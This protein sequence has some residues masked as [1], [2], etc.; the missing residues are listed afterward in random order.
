MRPHT[1]H[2]SFLIT[3]A[4]LALC[5]QALLAGT[6]FESTQTTEA[7]GKRGDQKVVVAGW[8][9]G[10]GA[11]VEFRE[12]TSPMVSEG[13]YIV[14]RDGGETAYLV[15]PEEK[16]YME[17]DL[18]AL[19]GSLGNMMQGMGGMVDMEFRDQRVEKVGEEPGPEIV[20]HPTTHHTYES[21]YTLVIRVMGM[22]R[23]MRTETVQEIWSTPELSAPGFGLWL[24]EAPE[25][26]IEGLDEYLEQE[27]SKAEGFP[28]RTKT[29][30][31]TIGQKGRESVSTTITE[32]TTLREESIPASRFEIPSGFTETEMPSL[33]AMGN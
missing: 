9:D 20:G 21:S 15:N 22:G 29:I 8:V 5:G 6:Y 10:P 33:G 13:T 27:M 30:T 1:L 4:A 32:V 3:V 19:V 17:W 11:R 7:E 23:E 25:T 24:Q 26:G 2:R 16:T 31:T 14:T 28:L 18:A 12:S